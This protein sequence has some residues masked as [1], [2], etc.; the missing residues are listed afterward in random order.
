M[1]IVCLKD[2]KKL[3]RVFSLEDKGLKEVEKKIEFKDGGYYIIKRKF[4]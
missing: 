2:I 4:I 3:G 1:D